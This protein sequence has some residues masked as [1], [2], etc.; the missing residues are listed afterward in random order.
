MSDRAARDLR[1]AGD[2]G[3]GAERDG[4]RHLLQLH[5]GPVDGGALRRHHLLLGGAR[6]RAKRRE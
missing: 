5:D 4:R 1:R 2:P 3:P 6:R